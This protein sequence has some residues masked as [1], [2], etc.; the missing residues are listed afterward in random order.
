MIPWIN[1][2]DGSG[3]FQLMKLDHGV[4]GSDNDPYTS[5][6]YWYEPNPRAAGS[7]GYN[8]FVAAG[9]AYDG[10][11]GTGKEV[12]ARMVLVNLNGGSVSAAD[13]PAK[14]TS[15]MPATGNV[16][17]ILST[18]PN[19]P[20]VSFTYTT[21]APTTGADQSVASAKKVGVF[22]NPYYAYNN[23]ETNRFDRFV[24]FNNL[25]KNVTIRI[26]NLAGQLVRTLQ[27][28]DDSQFT[29]WDLMNARNYPVASGVYVAYVELPDIGVT[30]TLKLSIIQQQEI[31]DLY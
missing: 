30:K 23:A 18:K 5:W 15:L 2:E 8:A 13:W 31:L 10:T 26:F 9:A 11:A 6:I 1:D 14:V 25:P 27:K 19:T 28:S 17:R 29:R 7:A 4:S 12:M 21:T 20:S 16:I 24:T 3:K 22:P